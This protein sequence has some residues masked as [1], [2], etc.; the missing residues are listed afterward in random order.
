METTAKNEEITLSDLVKIVERKPHT[1]RQYLKRADF[2]DELRPDVANGRG[3][4]VW[5]AEQIEGWKDYV[6]ERDSHRGWHGSLST[7]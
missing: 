6:R 7:G 2:P 4:M 1:I 5:R 3:K